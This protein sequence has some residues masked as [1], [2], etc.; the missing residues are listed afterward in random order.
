MI[1]ERTDFRVSFHIY[2]L[3]YCIRQIIMRQNIKITPA[4]CGGVIHMRL[5]IARLQYSVTLHVA[6]MDTVPFSLNRRDS[7]VPE[8]HRI[9]F[10]GRAEKF[11]CQIINLFLKCLLAIKFFINDK[12]ER[13][14]QFCLHRNYCLLKADSSKKMSWGEYPKVCVNLQTDVR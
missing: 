3:L 14:D 1:Y 5:L 6:G 2:A 10:A 11:F 4:L 12:T 8:Y 13:F 9:F 7:V